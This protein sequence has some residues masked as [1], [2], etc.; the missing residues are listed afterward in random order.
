MMIDPPK[1]ELS[2]DKNLYLKDPNSSELGKKIIQQS[3]N[4]IDQL[5]FENFTF[6]KLSELVGSSE[7]SIY[8]YFESKYKLLLYLQAWYWNWVDFNVVTSTQPLKS[9]IEKLK[10]SLNLLTKP[11]GDFLGQEYIDA[12]ALYRIVVA[13][14]SKVYLIKDVDQV[15]KEGLFLSYKRLCKRVAAFVEDINPKYP[16][17]RALISSIIECSHYQKFFASHLPSL[18]EVKAKNLEEVTD[19]LVDLAFKTIERT[20]AIE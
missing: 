7:P 12:Q 4:L 2:L 6:K 18:T 5:G 19:F 15:N 17:P 1:I 3:I 9:S 11:P 8:R 14:S 13:E 20:E 10:V 16:Y